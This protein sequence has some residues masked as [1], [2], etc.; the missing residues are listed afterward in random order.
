MASAFGKGPS[1]PAEVYASE[2]YRCYADYGYPL[3][4]PDT[5]QAEGE[6]FIGDVGFMD[7]GTFYRMFNAMKSLSGGPSY[8]DNAP[9]GYQP[10]EFPQ[11]SKVEAKRA[12]AI[13]AGPLHSKSIVVKK[14]SGSLDVSNPI[15][16]NR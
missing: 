2:L 1:G 8:D 15:H 7:H 11:G 6:V 12:N 5:I 3:W 10:F 14:L 4:D 16:A 9:E 13:Q